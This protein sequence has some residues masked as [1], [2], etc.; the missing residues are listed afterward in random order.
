M[1]I[2]VYIYSCLKELEKIIIIIFNKEGDS[3]IVWLGLCTSSYTSQL[4]AIPHA[5]VI[6]KPAY[7]DTES[8]D[9]CR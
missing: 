5:D 9:R 1:Y 2:Y 3:C 6:Q 8:L 7:R 4:F